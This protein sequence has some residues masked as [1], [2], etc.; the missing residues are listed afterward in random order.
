MSVSI[1]EGIKQMD[2]RTSAA[3][4]ARVLCE[5]TP[6]G[7][8][9]V[10]SIERHPESS[11]V[12]G[13]NPVQAGCCGCIQTFIYWFFYIFSFTLIDLFPASDEASDSADSSCIPENSQSDVCPSQEQQHPLGTD[14]HEV[15][16]T[17]EEPVQAVQ[18][19]I[20]I[21]QRSE[22]SAKPEVLDDSNHVSASDVLESDEE[23]DLFLSHVQA[24]MESAAATLQEIEEEFQQ[25]DYSTEIIEAASE[26][27]ALPR[28]PRPAQEE[29]EEAPIQPVMSKNEI[30]HVEHSSEESNDQISDS[31]AVLNEDESNE[32][33]EEPFQDGLTIPCLIEQVQQQSSLPTSLPAILSSPDNLTLAP[34]SAGEEPFETEGTHEDATKD[35]QPN[36]KRG[37]GY[38]SLSLTEALDDPL[39][40]V[41]GGTTIIHS[42]DEEEEST[43][44]TQANPA[45]S[46]TDITFRSPNKAAVRQGH[47]IIVSNRRILREGVENLVGKTA[48][49]ALFEWF[50]GDK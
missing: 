50:G 16:S 45:A 27:V 29:S 6:Q 47:P 28:V 40:V 15:E 37:L 46:Q 8:S 25:V 33:S 11:E 7:F 43:S 39:G 22:D 20:E 17:S 14:Q 42:R 10:S 2:I 21:H 18:E 36:E 23:E 41:N 48:S 26:E 34:S 44:S 9:S 31:Q 30:L 19:D 35:Q 24:E 4:Q 12:E 1:N 38:G 49:K 3:I 13:A 32:N 5:E